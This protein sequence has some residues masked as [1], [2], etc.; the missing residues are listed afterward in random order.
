[1]LY[2]LV[3]FIQYLG[4]CNYYLVTRTARGGA[5]GQNIGFF[6]E[7]RKFFSGFP[8]TEKKPYEAVAGFP[9]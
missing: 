7:N 5:V 2:T 1:M 4:K 6:F 8:R 3:Y 9:Y